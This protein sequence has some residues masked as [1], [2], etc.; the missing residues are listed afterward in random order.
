MKNQ[1]R[2]RDF[3]KRGLGQSADLRGD[4]FEGG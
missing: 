2:W 4:V 3:L 1:Y